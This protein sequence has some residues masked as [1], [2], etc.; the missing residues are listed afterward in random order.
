MIVTRQLNIKDREGHFF[1]HMININNF[2]PGLL[3]VDRTAID[4]N[5]IVYDIKYVKNLNKI[6]SLYIVF[7][8]LDIIFRKS[9]KDKYLIL[10]S[11][12]TNKMMLE[13][14]TETFD[15]IAEQIESMSDDKVKYHK[16]IM[17]IKFKTSDDIVFNEIINI[18]V[19]LK[20]VSSVFKENDWYHPQISLH[21]CFY[22]KDVAPEDI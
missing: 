7:N 22:E 17:R 15:E 18:F 11:T 5:F 6:D 9:G 8:N 21:D 13:N 4:Y 19:C 2:D 14:Y 16:D 12:E 20:V 3:H 10:S 1:T